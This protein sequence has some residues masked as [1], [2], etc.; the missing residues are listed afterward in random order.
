MWTAGTRATVAGEHL[1]GFGLGQTAELWS[2]VTT[3]VPRRL[4]LLLK[5]TKNNVQP[6]YSQLAS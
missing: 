5:N 4:P 1:C 3:L 2:V 6:Q